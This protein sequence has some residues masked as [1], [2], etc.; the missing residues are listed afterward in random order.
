MRPCKGRQ[1]CESHSL[2]AGEQSGGLVGIVSSTITN[3]AQTHGYWALLWSQANGGD[4]SSPATSPLP[5][6]DAPGLL[7]YLTLAGGVPTPIQNG[8][9]GYNAIAFSYVT[10]L[11]ARANP[12]FS[13]Y[14]VAIPGQTVHEA[15]YQAAPSASGP[16]GTA[17]NGEI[18]CAGAVPPTTTPVA[19]INNAENATFYPILATFGFNVTQVQAAASLHGTIATVWLGQNDQLK[20]VLDPTAVPATDPGQFGSDT[21][22]IIETLQASGARVVVSNLMDPFHAAAW[23]SQPKI[24]VDYPAY[25]QQIDAVLASYGVGPNGYVSFFQLAA[26]AAELEAGQSVPPLAVGTYVPD[27]LAARAESLDVAYNQRI[28]AAAAATGAALV[29][30]HTMESAAFAAGGIPITATCCHVAYGGG[31]YSLD[32]LHPSNTFYAILAN[33]FIAKIDQR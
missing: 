10:A 28:A 4:V 3:A 12:A 13:P 15:L 23:V 18:A 8:C 11:T 27:A 19:L 32:G 31:F 14:D 7:S 33:S 17:V 16:T 5:L 20:H 25:A 29:D 1:A 9:Q 6:I 24:A 22:Q 30:I 26:M 2:T 21:T